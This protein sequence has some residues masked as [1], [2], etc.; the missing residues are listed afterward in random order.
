MFTSVFQKEHKP[1]FQS[2]NRRNEIIGGNERVGIGRKNDYLFCA[3]T[4]KILIPFLIYHSPGQEGR[5]HA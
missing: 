2:F 4:F 5:Q 3:H 1:S